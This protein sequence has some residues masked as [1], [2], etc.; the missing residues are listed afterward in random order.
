MEAVL[1]KAEKRDWAVSTIIRGGSH[2]EGGEK[3]LGSEHHQSDTVC[4]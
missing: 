4:N 3:G 1:K 2:E